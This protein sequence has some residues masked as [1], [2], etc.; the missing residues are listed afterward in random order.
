MVKSASRTITEADIVNFSALT[1]DHNPLHTNEE[2]AK[3]T[4]HGERIA[5]GALTF[6]YSV[7]LMNM[8][9]RGEGT[10][11]AYAGINVKYTAP[12]H[13]GDT[14]HCVCTVT[15]KKETKKADRGLIFQKVDVVNQNGVTVVEEECTL[16]VRRMPAQ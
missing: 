5:H 13:P 6:A 9:R 16:M 4:P 1:W 10:V 15:D 12:V 3:T 8:L 2:F 14:I 7:G 11:I